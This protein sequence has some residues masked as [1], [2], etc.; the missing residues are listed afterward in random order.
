MICACGHEFDE[1]TEEASN[2]CDVEGC[3]CFAYEW[4][5]PTND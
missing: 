3:G 5:G 1:H 2:P 4:E